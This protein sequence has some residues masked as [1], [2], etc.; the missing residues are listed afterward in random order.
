MIKYNVVLMSSQRAIPITVKTKAKSIVRQ[1][2][3]MKEKL[4]EIEKET[5]KAFDELPAIAK[6]FAQDFK[7]TLEAYIVDAKKIA[8]ELEKSISSLELEVI[9]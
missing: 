9:R 1:F 8:S 7:E 4:E 2:S 6:P 3:R 5:K